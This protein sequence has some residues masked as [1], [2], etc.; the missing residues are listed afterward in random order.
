VDG[1]ATTLSL[2]DLRKLPQEIEEECICVGHS[3][4]F[5]GIFD[6]TGPRLTPLLENLKAVKDASD[7]RKE[8]LYVVLSGTDGYQVVASWTELTQ[9]ADGKRALIALDKGREPLPAEEGK[10]RL[11][12]PADKYVGR[13]VKSLERVEVRLAEGFKDIGG[14]HAK[15]SKEAK[16]SKEPQK[17]AETKAKE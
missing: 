8:N 17:P 7:Y 3:V 13:S 15:E 5:I 2:E 4:G 12:L 6:F 9:S 10:L 11:I 14:A 1:T 16:D